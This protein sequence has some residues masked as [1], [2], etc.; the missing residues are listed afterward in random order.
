MIF[1]NPKS[2]PFIIQK[3]T[4]LVFFWLFCS[5]WAAKKKVGRYQNK[6]S[7]RLIHFQINLSD[8]DMPATFAYTLC[9]ALLYLVKKTIPAKAIRF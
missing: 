4:K 5:T 8:F 9:L 7:K 3:K 2:T 1:I 6:H